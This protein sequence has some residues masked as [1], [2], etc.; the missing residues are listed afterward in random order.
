[1][2]AMDLSVITEWEEK[3][4]RK[5]LQSIASFVIL[6]CQNSSSK[7]FLL[8]R[9][10]KCC[11]LDNTGL[12]EQHIR[13]WCR[14]RGVSGRKN[15]NGPLISVTVLQDQSQDIYAHSLLTRSSLITLLQ[16]T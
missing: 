8:F 10:D 15:M 13:V 1:M 16:M 12:L 4:K 5:Q 2:Q 3:K 11:I 14:A 6:R 9:A 7:R